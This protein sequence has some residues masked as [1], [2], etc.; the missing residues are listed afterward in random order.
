MDEEFEKESET[1]RNLA[2]LKVLDAY[3]KK[4]SKTVEK[5]WIDH[6][7]VDKD[8]AKKLVGRG[9]V[10]ISKMKPKIKTKV[11]RDKSIRNCEMYKATE[12]LKQGRRCEQ[13]NHRIERGKAADEE[14]KKKYHN[15]NKEAIDLII[16]HLDQKDE[17]DQ[18]FKG[19]LQKLRKNEVE[20]I[21][22]PPAAVDGPMARE[23]GAGETEVEPITSDHAAGLA[24]AEAV[25]KL[26]FFLYEAGTSVEGRMQEY[27]RKHGGC[28]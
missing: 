26:A 19:K 18:D 23:S 2:S 17:K 25:I 27:L 10:K 4:Y 1:L 24:A 5:V 3:W 13:I 22:A 20:A 6:M 9:E 8:T 11:E 21:N 7:E 28:P 14:K 12:Y 16:K 15:L